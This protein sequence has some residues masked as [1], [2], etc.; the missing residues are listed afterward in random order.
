MLDLKFIRENPDAVKIAIK[1]KNEK[2]DVDHV[3]DLDRKR[4]DLTTEAQSLK[5]KRNKVS[6]DIAKL[7]RSGGDASAAIQEMRLVS[8]RVAGLDSELREVDEALQKELLWIPNI[9]HES[10]PVGPDETFNVDIR[11]WGDKPKF[12]FEPAPHWELGD[13]LGLFDLARGAKISG[14]GFLLFTGMGAKLERALINFMVDL[15]TSRHGFVELSPPFVVT[16]ETM[17]GTGQI[18]KLRD[19]MYRIEDTNLYLIPTAEVP[20]TNTHRDE[21]IPETRL[22]LKYVAY[23]PCFRKE[24]GA[25]G[26]DTRGLIRVHQFDK[27]EMVMF[28]HPERSWQAIEELVEC[29]EA[30]LQAL[31]LP[32]RVRLLSTGDLS[33]SAAK[34]Y[35]L[36]VFSA[37]VDKYLEVSSCSNFTDFQARRANIR[38]KPEGGKSQYVHTL[39]GSGLALPRT[40]IAIIEN[41]QTAKGTVR[42]PVALR[43]YLGG[44]DEIA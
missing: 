30:V 7:K 9:P 11:Y 24:A 12:D 20:V 40:V 19:D 28:S 37:G 42:V 34:C 31:E 44:L 43:S 41:Y 25:H 32:Y 33:F 18:P 6:D 3:L 4:R 22:P 16:E 2:A 10:V 17:T 39:N 38:F 35:D 26:K 13:K 27:V 5:E 1:N 23:T 21:T 36:E 8:D 14:S 29:A 15:H